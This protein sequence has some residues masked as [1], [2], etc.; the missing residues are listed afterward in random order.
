MTFVRYYGYY[1]KDKDKYPT[2][3]PTNVIQNEN[4]VFIFQTP[5]NTFIPEMEKL[6]RYINRDL[7]IFGQN[8]K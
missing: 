8:Y 1:L 6:E 4:S 7:K 2:K 3:I 5:A